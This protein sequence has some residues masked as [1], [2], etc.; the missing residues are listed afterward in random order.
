MK[1]PVLPVFLCPECGRTVI[2]AGVGQPPIY[3]STPCRQ[4]RHRKVKKVREDLARAE[5]EGLSRRVAYLS[6]WLE[7]LTDGVHRS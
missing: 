4:R 2:P 3:C 5:A 6:E 1:G 7:R